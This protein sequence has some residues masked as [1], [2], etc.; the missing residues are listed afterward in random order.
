MSNSV[1]HTSFPSVVVFDFDGTL[2]TFR[3]GWESDMHALMTEQIAP[4]DPE[5]VGIFVDAY[6]DQS[7]GIQTIFQ[8]E[9]LREQVIQRGENPVV[10]DAWDY[11][12]LYNEMLMKSVGGRVRDVIDGR[13][14]PDRYLVAGAR[15]FLEALRAGGARL[16][17][18]SGTDDAD[19]KREAKALG[20][21]VYFERINGAPPLKKDCS[22]ESLIRELIGGQGISGG[23]VLVVGDGKVEIRLGKEA[24]A[25]TLGIASDEERGG[26][27]ERK[28]DRLRQASADWIV[29]DFSDLYGIMAWINCRHNDQD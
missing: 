3:C 9:W 8:M 11:K 7:T 16:F 26:F 27:S 1:S 14:S 29:G 18:A 6:I 21:D 24:G 2:S 5:S 4:S 15:E 28:A 23:D 25:R 17:A 12:A 19:V 22:K 20:L 13:V 10:L